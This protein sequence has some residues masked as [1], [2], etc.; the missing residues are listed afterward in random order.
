M[1]GLLEGQVA[2]DGSGEQKHVLQYHPDVAAQ[3]VLGQVRTLTPSTVTEPR[4][5]S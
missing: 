4:C 5:T 1:S 3:I 2:L